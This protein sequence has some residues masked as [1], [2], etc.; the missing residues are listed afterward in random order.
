MGAAPP[1]SGPERSRARARWEAL[2][3]DAPREEYFAAARDALAEFCLADP[4]NPYRQSGRTSGAARWEATRRCIAEAVDR[5][6]DFLDVG[7]AN[8]LLLES[9][10]RWCAERGH[11]IRPHGIDFI[12]ELVELARRRHP[13]REACFEVTN[14]WDWSPARR[15]D[16]VRTNLEY[17]PLADWPHFVA[18]QLAVVAAGGRLIVCHYRNAADPVVDVASVL[19]SLGHRVAGRAGAD[20]VSLAWLDVG[21]RS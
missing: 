19:A 6:G 16:Y 9:L 12:P 17:V 8:G 3:A 18:C 13:G 15:Y 11:T 2:P 20:G 21:P 10:V 14:A 4:S 5:D 7:C 1:V